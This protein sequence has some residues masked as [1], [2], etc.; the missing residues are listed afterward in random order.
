[1]KKILLW[2]SLLVIALFVV[3]CAPK[4][5]GEESAEEGA[6]AG[7]AVKIFPI[8][9]KVSNQNKVISLPEDSGFVT[10]RGM[11]LYD[12]DAL[13]K[14]FTLQELFLAEGEADKIKNKI[15]ECIIKETG[16]VF[17]LKMCESKQLDWPIDDCDTCTKKIT[18]KLVGFSGD[19]KSA[20]IEFLE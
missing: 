19:Q 15:K 1:M 14:K 4:E 3:S 13:G 9:C 8:S 12:S 11:L 17:Q 6:L 16:T 20:L 2:L 10:G 18:V 5:T 7:E